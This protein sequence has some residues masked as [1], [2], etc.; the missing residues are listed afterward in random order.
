MSRI[1]EIRFGNWIRWIEQSLVRRRTDSSRGEL[2]AKLISAEASKTN[3]VRAYSSER[4]GRS[5]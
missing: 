3:I 2:D 4:S 5:T 1:E